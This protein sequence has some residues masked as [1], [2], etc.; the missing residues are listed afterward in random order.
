[1]NENEVSDL[2]NQIFPENYDYKIL[3]YEKFEIG[4]DDVKF[5][6][7]MRVNVTD[8][9]EVN[10]YLQEFYQSSGCNFNM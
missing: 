7:E 6:I 8:K 3:N 4:T 1:M 10:K 2:I 9:A 5:C